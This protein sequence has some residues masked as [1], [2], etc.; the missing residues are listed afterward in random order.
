MNFPLIISFL[1]CSVNAGHLM[2]GFR[3][4][5]SISQGL[6]VELSGYEKFQGRQY[7]KVKRN[8]MED[9][10]EMYNLA[11]EAMEKLYGGNGPNL[12][13]F[14]KRGRGGLMTNMVGD[15]MNEGW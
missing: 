8:T 4:V 5:V 14:E 9:N 6:R 1:F 11:A 15:M 3:P 12:A 2:P 10:L 7:G 13:L